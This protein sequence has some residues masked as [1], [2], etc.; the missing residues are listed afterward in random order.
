MRHV[1]GVVCCGAAAA[2]QGDR[3][4]RPHW[5]RRARSVHW[6]RAARFACHLAVTLSP[7]PVG[8]TVSALAPWR[9]TAVRCPLALPGSHRCQPATRPAARAVVGGGVQDCCC[10][11][12]CCCCCARRRPAVPRARSAEEEATKTERRRQAAGTSR[13]REPTCHSR[14]NRGRTMAEP[15]QNPLTPSDTFLTVMMSSRRGGRAAELRRNRGGTAA[16]CL[17]RF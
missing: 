13:E 12:C 14:Q 4:Y 3:A 7:Y 17:T 15:R 5:S 9:C 10:C 1:S 6:H 11:C 16:E 2:A 8:P